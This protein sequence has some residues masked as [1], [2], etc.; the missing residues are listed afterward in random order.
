MALN[1]PIGPQGTAAPLLVRWLGTVPYANALQIQEE[2]A[3]LRAAGEAP[4]TLLLLEHPPTIT[5]GRGADRANVLTPPELLA[6]RG[7]ALVET[8]RGGDVTFHGPGQLVGYPILNLAA[9]SPAPDLHRY[10]RQLEEV[11][12]Q[13][14][15]RFGV[16]GAR[17]P[18]H[19]GVWTG[20]PDAPAKAAAIGIKVSRWITRHGFALNCDI[21][22]ADFDVIVPCGIRDFPVTSIS[23]ASGHTVSVESARSMVVERFAEVFGME[24]RFERTQ[25]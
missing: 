21:D 16:T 25:E 22:L 10:L 19:T 2:T 9:L 23:R 5:L 4:D 11:L 15:A 20:F 3:A 17:F 18:P 12:I 1:S 6:A 24:T 13:T 8:D 14:L 7:I